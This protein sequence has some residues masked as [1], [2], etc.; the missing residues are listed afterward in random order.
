MPQAPETD[1]DTDATPA[2]QARP[3][4][5]GAAQRDTRAV[6]GVPI[7][8]VDEGGAVRRIAGWARNGDSR[9]VCICNVHSVVTAARDPGFDAVLRA[10]DMATPD[11]APVAWMLRRR[12]ARGQGRVSG[13]DLMLAYCAHAAAAGEPLFLLGG[14][15]PTLQLL[16]QRLQERWPALRIAGA[17]APPFRPATAAEDEALVAAIHA[18]GA[19]T[20]WGCRRGAQRERWRALAGRAQLQSAV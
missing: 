5:A 1:T 2:A 6:L 15:A 7:D 17:H 12:G 8:V 11:G 20:V 4:A 3:A 10:A 19:R 16:Q 14:T 18:S 13:P 9:S